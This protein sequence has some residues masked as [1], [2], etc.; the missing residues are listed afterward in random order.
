MTEGP[1]FNLPTVELAGLAGNP[2][3]S[4][5]A[6]QLALLPHLTLIENIWWCCWSSILGFL[7]IRHL[8]LSAVR[9]RGGDFAPK[10][11]G[12]E[13]LSLSTKV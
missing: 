11:T 6:I 12:A 2:P 13:D 8:L 4:L 3:T 7:F 5:N 9:Q 10:T 1:L